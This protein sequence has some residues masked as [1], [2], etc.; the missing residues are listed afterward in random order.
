M[1]SGGAER[2]GRA[3]ALS[4]DAPLRLLNTAARSPSLL[5]PSALRPP[6]P[7]SAGSLSVLSVQRYFFRSVFLQTKK[8]PFLSEQHITPSV[9][10]SRGIPV[11]AA[12]SFRNLFFWVNS[13]D[14]PNEP[15]RIMS[16]SSCPWHIRLPARAPC[17]VPE[18]AQCVAPLSRCPAKQSALV[19][20]CWS[21]LHRR[22]GGR[23]PALAGDVC[24]R[25]YST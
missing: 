25:V 7:A 16:V 15:R 23:P 18:A 21:A 13:H 11:P 3:S 17:A 10:K 9:F 2:H 1:V 5:R 20:P 19:S 4:P 6:F 8:L 12:L 24:V 14:G 22:L